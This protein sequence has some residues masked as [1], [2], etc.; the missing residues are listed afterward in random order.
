[1]KSR[2]LPVQNGQ[3]QQQLKSIA[4]N[5]L[6]AVKEGLGIIPSLGWPKR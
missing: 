6:V 2:L 1:M 3:E 4:A 5:Q